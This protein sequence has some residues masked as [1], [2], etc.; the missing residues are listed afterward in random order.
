M[1]LFQDFQGCL[2]F[3]TVLICSCCVFI[4]VITILGIVTGVL[5][6]WTFVLIIMLLSGEEE[7]N[8][9]APSRRRR[10]LIPFFMFIIC[11]L[12][13][14]RC[15]DCCCKRFNQFATVPATVESAIPMVPIQPSAP[16]DISISIPE[17]DQPPKYDQPPSYNECVRSNNVKI[18][19]IQVV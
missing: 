9:I 14:L 13:L 5:N 11:V 8:S 6:G 15:L 3:I 1:G 10:S 2:D 4:F 16:D 17:S 19:S 18:D 12:F 7:K